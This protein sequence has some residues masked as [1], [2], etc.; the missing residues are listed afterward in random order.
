[1][2]HGEYIKFDISQYRKRII[3]INGQIAKLKITKKNIERK[4]KEAEKRFGVS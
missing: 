2:N 4:L 3:S 1:M